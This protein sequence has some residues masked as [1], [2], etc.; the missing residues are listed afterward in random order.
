MEDT[1][2]IRSR[3]HG[4]TCGGIVVTQTW[5]RRLPFMRMMAVSVKKHAIS[6]LDHI[7]RLQLLMFLETR[8]RQRQNWTYDLFKGS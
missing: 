8:S 3:P 5:R 2:G 7:F 6:S 4:K 1:P